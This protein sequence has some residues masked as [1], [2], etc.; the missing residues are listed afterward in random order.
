M[1]NSNQLKMERLLAEISELI[2]MIVNHKGPII[3]LK[4]PK[5]VSEEIEKARVI[6]DA[7]NDFL[8]DSHQSSDDME[9]LAKRKLESSEVSNNEKQLLRHSL[10]VGQEAKVLQSAFALSLKRRKKS[11]LNK[12]DDQSTANKKQIKER[13]KLFKTIGGD[14]NW[15]PM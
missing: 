4:N 2:D 15:I 12:M 13:R 7:I 6:M 3:P 9:T 1:E 8:D 5:E 10:E 11:K 14:K